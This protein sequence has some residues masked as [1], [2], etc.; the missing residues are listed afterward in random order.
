MKFDQASATTRPVPNGRRQ[1]AVSD[2]HGAAAPAIIV[3]TVVLLAVV[4]IRRLLLLLRLC[5]RVAL[6]LWG[7]LEG[8]LP[9]ATGNN[10]SSPWT[11]W[12]RVYCIHHHWGYSFT[13]RSN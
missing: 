4:V 5:R 9:F 7:V 6:W 1:Q 8:G 3:P 2:A 10:Q 11:C 13:S 12:T